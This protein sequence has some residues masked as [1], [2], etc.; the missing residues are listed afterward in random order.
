M[1]LL[2]KIANILA[3]I[4]KSESGIGDKLGVIGDWDV[5]FTSYVEPKNYVESRELGGQG[6]VEEPEG[7]DTEYDE[8]NLLG[9]NDEEIVQEPE[10][11]EENE[12]SEG[13]LE[14]SVGN[15]LSLD[16][17]NLKEKIMETSVGEIEKS[18]ESDSDSEKTVK[19]KEILE[20]EKYNDVSYWKPHIL[21]ETLE[22]L[23]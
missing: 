9:E 22:D 23:S 13:N 10:D 18:K 1:G 2:T 16:H 19:S 21:P 14:G 8:E 5:F 4:S 12:K 15:E 6:Y 11:I 7:V 20:F 17:E 3:K